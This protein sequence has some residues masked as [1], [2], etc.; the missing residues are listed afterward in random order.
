MAD[1]Q[2]S[3]GGS[4]LTWRNDKIREC[5]A[6]IKVVKISQ[7]QFHAILLMSL[8]WRF[9]NNWDDNKDYQEIK[10]YFHFFADLR[11]PVFRVIG[12]L[13]PTRPTDRNSSLNGN[14]GIFGN[15]YQNDQSFMQSRGAHP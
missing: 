7:R 6:A 1:T 9:D 15:N 13:K 14:F 10:L 11:L 2:H 12:N 3:N 5:F 8:Q 4:E